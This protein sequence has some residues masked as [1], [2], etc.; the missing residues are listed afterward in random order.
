MNLTFWQ[1]LLLWLGMYT[2]RQ[3][4][5]V[6]G[7]VKRGVHCRWWTAPANYPA[8]LAQ[9]KPA[10]VRTPLPVGYDASGFV[11][12]VKAADG[13]PLFVTSWA[14]TQHASDA[15]VLGDLPILAGYYGSAATQFPGCAWELGNEP[16]VA[17]DSI[18]GALQPSTVIAYTK[19][20]AAAIRGADPTATIISAGLSGLDAGYGA[21]ISPAYAFVDAIGAHPYG[22]PESGVQYQWY[23]SPLWLYGKPVWFTEYGV[24][25][26]QGTAVHD[27]FAGAQGNVPVAIYF[28]LDD[29]SDGTFGL[30]DAS[31]NPKPSFSQF[32]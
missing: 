7:P 2:L 12:A 15:I 32:Q 11:A 17:S 24:S 4:V 10:F 20:L 19:A 21:A 6:G 3:P 22:C 26:P 8:L 5:G 9:L 16:N 28:E 1:R 18:D 14:T 30:V 23:L 27:Y 25:N 31:G 13:V 29:N